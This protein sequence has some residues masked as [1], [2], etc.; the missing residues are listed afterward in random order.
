LHVAR[1]RRRERAKARDDVGIGQS[2]ATGQGVSCEKDRAQIALFAGFEAPVGA[3]PTEPSRFQ[4]R[5]TRFIP[6]PDFLRK[7]LGRSSAG[8][9]LLVRLTLHRGDHLG[10]FILDPVRHVPLHPLRVRAMHAARTHSFS[11][12][13]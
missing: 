3:L 6:L 4:K 5:R 11:K 1:G 12:S 2:A 10:D 13:E 8:K 7:R 9:P